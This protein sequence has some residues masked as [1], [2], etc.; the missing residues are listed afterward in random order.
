MRAPYEQG[1]PDGGLARPVALAL[2]GLA[3]LLV[4]GVAVSTARSEPE[5]DLVVARE[6]AAWAS[7]A[8]AGPSE[9]SGELSRRYE[10]CARAAGVDPGGVQVLLWESN[11]PV[12]FGAPAPAAGQPWWVKTGRD[13]PASIHRP[14]FR[15]IGGA[16]VEQSS[17]GTPGG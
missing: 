2:A 11:D 10:R 17:H 12:S 6:P 14:C 1:T 5:P 7:S 15:A 9:R 13:V 3:G 4:T 8:E 16:E